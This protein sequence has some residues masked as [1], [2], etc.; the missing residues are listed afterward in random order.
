MTTDPTLNLVVNGT[1]VSVA[2]SSLFH[3]LTELDYIQEGCATAVNGEFVSQTQ[4]EDF[5]LQ[6]ND[7]IEI[8]TA[9]QGG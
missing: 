2:A 4:R 7:K 1:P 6:D 3:L 8:V 5:R 9:R